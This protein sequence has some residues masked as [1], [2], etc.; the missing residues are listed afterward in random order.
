[1]VFEWGSC[2]K[3]LI[4]I[5]VMQ[6]VED[7]LL[8]LNKD[9]Q[10]YLPED[11]TMPNSYDE[12]ITILHLMNHNAGFD[13][14]YTDLMVLNPV[15]MPTLRQALEQADIKQVFRPGDVVAYSNYGS[16]L[17]AYIVEVISGMDYREY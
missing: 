14:S 7:G 6:L 1:T 12:P 16:A 11:F 8:D 3:I 10:G 13:D 15:K 4:W 5:S 9:I 2:S 17:A